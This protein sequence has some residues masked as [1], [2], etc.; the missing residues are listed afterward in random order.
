MV[1]IPF[2]Y[3]QTKGDANPSA[4]DPSKAA[5]EDPVK[6]SEEKKAKAVKEPAKEGSEK[7]PEV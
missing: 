7:E 2:A 5:T 1:Y 4:E 6:L 3:V